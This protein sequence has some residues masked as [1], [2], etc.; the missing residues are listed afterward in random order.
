MEEKYRIRAEE[1]RIRKEEE[2]RLREEKRLGLRREKAREQ[3][4]CHQYKGRAEGNGISLSFCLCAR[5]ALSSPY[6]EG[7]F[8][9]LSAY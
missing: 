5:E 7:L 9:N 2:H 3:G 6:E 8:R 4:S 1:E